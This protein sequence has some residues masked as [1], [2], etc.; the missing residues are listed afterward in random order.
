MAESGDNTAVEIE[1]AVA[2]ET[3]EA[4]K[5]LTPE[6]EDAAPEQEANNT[7][8]EKPAGGGYKKKLT[9][10]EAE[11]VRLNAELAKFS[12]ETSA[13]EKPAEK[14]IPEN[15]QTWQEYEDAKD[16]WT[17]KTAT[18]EAV[19][20]LKEDT[21]KSKSDDLLKAKV[22]AYEGKMEKARETYADYDEVTEAYDGPLTVEM[23]RE[24]LDSDSGAEIA[25]YLAKN[26]KEAEAMAGMSINGMI[27]AMGKL[28]AKLEAG[29]SERA[30]VKTT[31]APAPI[32]PV[33]GSSKVSEPNDRG[34]VEVA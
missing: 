3:V 2:T 20:V 24:M 22:E 5:E 14:P 27:R 34:Y 18:S 10:A 6:P 13:P 28:E 9:K 33:R 4:P 16:Q 7:Q 17:L 1:P 8:P 25:Y 15:Y 11:I 12:K 21:Q 19:K 29:K 26:P 32:T 31:K 23:Q 30:A